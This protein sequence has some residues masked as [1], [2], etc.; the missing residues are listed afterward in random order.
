MIEICRYS[1]WGAASTE[2]IVLF[3]S[4]VPSFMTK[5]CLDISLTLK[6]IFDG[7]SKLYIHIY[8]APCFTLTECGRLSHC[9]PS[10][11][12]PVQNGWCYTPFRGG[13]SE[14]G[15]WSPHE[16][17]GWLWS[18]G[19][20]SPPLCQWVCSTGLDLTGKGWWQEHEQRK[21]FWSIESVQKDKSTTV[22]VNSCVSF[23]AFCLPAAN[24]SMVMR[25]KR[26]SVRALP[27][28]LR[29][30]SGVGWSC[31]LWASASAQRTAAPNKRTSLTP[32]VSLSNTATNVSETKERE[33]SDSEEEYRITH[34]DDVKIYKTTLPKS[35]SVKPSAARASPVFLSMFSRQ[36]LAS[37]GSS[38]NRAWE[39]ETPQFK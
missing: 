24:S 14:A 34:R 8:Q 33:E 38:N 26:M 28:T 20:D 29:L 13:S 16:A 39:K 32:R 19:R 2:I 7:K 17:L 22:E 23:T 37:W 18:G 10:G 3:C 11:S 1:Q 9:N 27:R 30:F 6:P 12:P 21:K 4:M 15:Q 31:C 25:G 35:M 5:V 36:R